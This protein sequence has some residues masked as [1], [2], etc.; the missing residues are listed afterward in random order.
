[1]IGIQIVPQDG[2]AL[3]AELTKKEA[4]FAKRV[5]GRSIALVLR[6]ETRPNGDTRPIPVG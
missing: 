1:M 6:N 4:K 5:S 3:Y 2:L